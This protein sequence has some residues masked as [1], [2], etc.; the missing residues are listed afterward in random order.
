[1]ITKHC[2][3]IND[4]RLTEI[5]DRIDRNVSIKILTADQSDEDSCRELRILSHLSRVSW[6]MEHPGRN[7]IPTLKDHF[8]V[9]GPNGCHLCLLM[10][11]VGPTVSFV[12]EHCEGYRLTAKLAHEAS[13]QL[14]LAVDYLH[15]CG[16]AHGGVL[17]SF[18]NHKHLLTMIIDIHTGNVLFRYPGLD[19]LEREQIINVLH[20]P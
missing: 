14:L 11:V 18:L 20:T 3:L 12:Q 2:K 16:L 9:H 8:Y 7:Y 4:C 15:Q 17:L 5:Y 6:S 1:M 19:T 10:D 13:K